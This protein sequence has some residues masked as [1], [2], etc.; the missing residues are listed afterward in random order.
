M[1]LLF[2]SPPYLHHCVC[3]QLTHTVTTHR[4]KA[5]KQIE[6]NPNTA[7]YF[8]LPL[9]F[10]LSSSHFLCPTFSS[11]SRLACSVSRVAPRLGFPV[12]E[13]CADTRS[14]AQ[15]RREAYKSRRRAE[16][17]FQQSSAPKL[18]CCPKFLLLYFWSGST[19]IYTFLSL[20][21][22]PLSRLFST[23]PTYN[24]MWGAQRRQN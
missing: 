9:L 8:F 10:P 15:R 14:E 13:E 21:T 24:F 12:R 18:N 7:L 4:D 19:R 16:K 20:P 23:W 2:L 22:T 1:N 5:Q 3:G 6:L 17:Q 11:S